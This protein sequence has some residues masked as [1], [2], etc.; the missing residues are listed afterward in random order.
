V[1]TNIK[2]IKTYA[3]KKA[4]NIS[5]ATT[6]K[7]IIKPNKLPIKGVIPTMFNNKSK[8]SNKIFSKACPATILAN[9]RT[10]KLIK[11]IKKEINSIII[12]K[13]SNNFGASGLKRSK[14]RQ[15]FCSMLNNII[16]PKLVIEKKKTIEI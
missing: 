3:C 4:I 16:P 2:K 13:C 14:K 8:K 15:P 6:A 11:R 9:N 5:S 1:Y 10:A 12:K 7:I